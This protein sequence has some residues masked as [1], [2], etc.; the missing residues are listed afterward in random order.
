[1]I[2][3]V[4]ERSPWEL[5]LDALNPGD[6]LAAT[7][8]LLLLEEMSDAE[9][10]DALLLLEEN[11]IG[12]DVA[13]LPVDNGR[14]ETADRLRREQ[15]LAK[16]GNLLENLDE[17][18][19]LGVYLREIA[20]IPAAGDPQLLA[21][22]YAAGDESV[23]PSLT[24]LCL[25]LVVEKSCRMTGRGILL[26]DLIQ[27]AS[28]GLWQG[29][30]HYTAG[31]FD[32]HIRWWIELYL[33]KA[34]LMQARSSGLGEK[35]R[36]AMEDYRDMDQQLLS[37][38]GRNPTL[39]EIAEAIHI[40]PE[41]AMTI[42]AMLAQV[43]LRQQVDEARRP[44]ETTPDDE[45]AV[46]NTALFQSR[47]RI[48]DMLSTLTEQ[49]AKLLTLRFGLEGGLSKTPQQAGEILG[50]TAEEAVNMET[51]ALQKLRQQEK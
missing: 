26:L 15:Q 51:A 8:A 32:A 4:F 33:S 36:T 21:E 41:E 9:A 30:L 28:L 42:D 43:K 2:D 14:G 12:L 44:K 1:M 25:S 7:K 5:A 23:L 50:I 45:Q 49:E 6:T 19:P 47:Q 27:E 46:E 16:K 13:G 39:E 11:Q 20:R 17:N 31:D 38:L 48:L 37:Q 40:T 3:V 18:D 29:I 34:V 22:Q 24:N 35:L 10:E